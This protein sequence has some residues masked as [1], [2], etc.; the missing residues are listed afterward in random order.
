[1]RIYQKFGNTLAV[2]VCIAAF[3]MCA[4]L[5]IKDGVSTVDTDTGV[6]TY[7]Y[8]KGDFQ[9]YLFVALSFLVSAVATA[10]A[11]DLPLV[12]AGISILPL[13]MSFYQFA[14]G[15][16]FEIVAAI[17][18]LLALIHVACNVLAWWDQQA[19]KAKAKAKAQADAEADV[20]VRN[21][22]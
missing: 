18:L 9:G 7:F 1:M 4:V 22:A 3:V 15:N 16:L 17:V 21:E 2:L 14:V 10:C 19:D 5:V 6:T 8:E 20:E 11:A 12:S 13:A